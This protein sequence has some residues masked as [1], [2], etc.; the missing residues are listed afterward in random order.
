VKSG[1]FGTSSGF[2]IGGFSDV[3][4][5]AAEP[6]IAFLDAFSNLRGPARRAAY[7]SAGITTGMHVLDLGCGTGDDVRELSALVGPGGRVAGVDA[8]R[9]MIAAAS[10]RGVPANAELL[11]AS[12]YALP[13]PN[14]VFDSARAERVFQHLDRPDDAAAEVVR[15]LKPGGSFFAIDHDWETLDVVGGDPAVARRIAASMF[16][17][18]ARGGMGRELGP[19]LQRAGLRVVEVFSGTSMLPFDLAEPF[20]LRP[21]VAEAVF[22][23][24]I[25]A[26]EGAA[27]L[28][29]LAAA[30]RRGAFSYA[31]TAYAILAQR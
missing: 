7:R 2:R 1:P 30:D 12:A 25:V 20:A 31:V 26:E 13:F 21:A 17:S 5:E 11:V 23:G 9:A 10:A 29:A 18:V 3:D 24:A 19:L 16:A 15:V 27:W 22:R 4:A 14:A 8:S 6:Y 28:A